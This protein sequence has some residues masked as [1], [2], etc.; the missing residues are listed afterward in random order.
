MRNCLLGRRKRI[1]KGADNEVKVWFV[2]SERQE[3]VE[4]YEGR[5]KGGDERSS[6][7]YI[8]CL[9]K[10]YSLRKGGHWNIL[11]RK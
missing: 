10:I 9:M 4:V 11:L 3:D 5:K 6:G 1:Y 8:T 2:W 7:S